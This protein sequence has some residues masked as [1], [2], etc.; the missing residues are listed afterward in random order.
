MRRPEHASKKKK[1]RRFS[2][3]TNRVRAHVRTRIYNTPR[4]I[5]TSKTLTI[6]K[7]NKKFRR[8]MTLPAY[9]NPYNLPI[10]SHDQTYLD[11]NPELFL[12][13]ASDFKHVWLPIETVHA[14]G[15]FIAYEGVR[16]HAEQLKL[17][18]TYANAQPAGM[19]KMAAPEQQSYGARVLSWEQVPFHML[20]FALARN[21]K[22]PDAPGFSFGPVG[23]W[24]ERQIEFYHRLAP[25]K[26][27]EFVRSHVAVYEITDAR[28]PVKKLDATYAMNKPT[29][30]LRAFAEKATQKLKLLPPG[31]YLGEYTGEVRRRKRGGAEQTAFGFSIKPVVGDRAFR[32]ALIDYVVDAES[33]GNE[34]RFINDV[35]G[36]STK[37]E[38]VEPNVAFMSYWHGNA[39]HIGVLTT[40][41]VRIGEELLASY[42]ADYWYGHFSDTLRALGSSR[43]DLKGAMARE[44]RQRNKAKE[45]QE[46]LKRMRAQ[47]LEVTANCARSP[48]K[49][50][51]E[52]LAES[53]RKLQLESAE[54]ERLERK[55]QQQESDSDALKA[56]NGQ[57]LDA[58]KSRE[59]AALPR[60]K[61]DKEL[62]AARQIAQVMR[63]QYRQA[64]TTH[65]L[66]RDQWNA[67]RMRME[68]VIGSTGVSEASLRSGKYL[69]DMKES[70]LVQKKEL[71]GERAK[72]ANL[73][74]LC[75]DLSAQTEETLR[76]HKIE[77]EEQR[78]QNET[79]N[80]RTLE[81][82]KE[83]G[84]RESIFRHNEEARNNFITS[85]R[86]DFKRA[87]IMHGKQIEQMGEAL[88]S[89]TEMSRR[90]IT[91][92]T[93]DKASAILTLIT[94][95]QALSQ[96]L[97][98][99]QSTGACQARTTQRIYDAATTLNDSPV[100]LQL[101]AQLYFQPLFI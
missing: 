27:M 58:L 94:D 3:F 40:R 72:V 41:P 47:L 21:N 35:E 96:T 54:R 87:K 80:A 23:C 15:Q 65:K 101:T 34:F 7:A 43:E 88:R 19:P 92:L 37:T 29:Y 78:R 30:A 36:F 52:N 91:Q 90:S 8:V 56:L 61:D 42:G 62:V 98:I 85:L 17:H 11:G 97:L 10:I 73:Q 20:T 55:L 59:D 84:E 69:V 22:A 16:V 99:Q 68:A 24:L 48:E 9:E 66:E 53:Q 13:R 76:R 31:Q 39:A 67:E 50:T 86:K 25:D 51:L 5:E 82:E 95:I 89:A 75:D 74:I 81:I 28:H 38:T 71:D 64:L 100:I 6:D 32:K 1:K 45:D 93:R 44:T 60:I 79:L 70:A 63:D 33:V 46:E 49:E 12:Q 83:A 26:R 4:R 57:L 77:I 2:F 14:V 18:F